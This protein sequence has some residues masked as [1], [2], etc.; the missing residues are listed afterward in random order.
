[1]LCS[2][3]L[4][5]GAAADDEPH[6]EAHRE[7]RP[8]TNSEFHVRAERAPGNGAN[9]R[10]LEG[11][12][13]AVDPG[14]HNADPR[15]A[16]GDQVNAEAQTIDR[17][18]ATVSKKLAA[19]N[20]LRLRRLR[21]AYRILHAPLAS[22]A[23]D[24]DRMVS[25]R[26]RAAARLLLDRDS[27]ERG[28]LAGEADRLRGAQLRAAAELTQLPTVSL[29]DTLAWPARGKVARH[30]GI[31][32]HERS[33]ATLSRRGVDLEVDDHAAASA[34]ADGIVRYAGPMRGLDH[35]VILDHGDYF[36]VIA[37]LGELAIPVG[38]HVSSGDRIGRASRHRVYFEVRVKIGPGG[39]PIDPEPL[40]A[41]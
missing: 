19:A 12:P 27:A 31:Y 30:F 18:L 25:A 14:S 7:P 2:L 24:A 10:T 26:R 38:T 41:R 39:L 22:D 37:K 40:L 5:S 23:S 20:A 9:R 29:P 36:T 16:L 3:A 6:P 11:A 28:L 4:V 34:P 8:R 17:T 13:D 32:E 15:T 33:H 35:G 1:M 21:A